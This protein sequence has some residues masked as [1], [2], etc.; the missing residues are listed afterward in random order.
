MNAGITIGP[1]VRWTQVGPGDFDG[2]GEHALYKVHQLEHKETG[3]GRQVIA[4]RK[5][6]S[7]MVARKVGENPFK[8]VGGPY[9]TPEEAKQRAEGMELS[10]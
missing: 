10:L 7:W 8:V 2:V 1:S 9:V 6:G 3:V 4:N 5:G